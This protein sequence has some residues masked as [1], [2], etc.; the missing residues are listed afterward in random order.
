MP[1]LFAPSKV[2]RS[3]EV[4]LLALG[5]SST[6]RLAAAEEPAP[7][8]NLSLPPNAPQTGPIPGGIAPA[9]HHAPKDRDDWRFDF[10]GMLMVPLR[11]GIGSRENPVGDQSK[12]TLHAP[13]VIP[14]YRDSFNYTGTVPQSYVGLFFT[15]GNPLVTANISIVSRQPR[16]GAS[17]FDPPLNPGIED[18]YLNFNLRQI[19]RNARFDVN[20][21]AFSLRYGVMGEW[22]EGRYATPII[23]R[24]N[25]IGEGIGA[26]FAFGKLALLVNQ[27]IQGQGDRPWNGI[28]ADYSNGFADSRT[29]AGWVF[30]E[31]LGVNYA[32]MATLA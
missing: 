25:G 17:Y 28:V 21:G 15:Y 6:T 30:G 12:T 5:L 20:V 24:T 18:A 1:A 19:M 3:I 10:H 2:P 7:D 26:T 27:E 23:A 31:H 14:D 9:Y 11:A 16:L 4:V 22:D 8:P 32:G 29:G 13:P